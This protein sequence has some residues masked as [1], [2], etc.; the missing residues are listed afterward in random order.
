[1]YFMIANWCFVAKTTSES[2]RKLESGSDFSA[3]PPIVSSSLP[4]G[5]FCCG[6]NFTCAMS[7]GSNFGWRTTRTLL[8][9]KGTNMRAGKGF[10]TFG[11][12]ASCTARR[13]SESMAP[14]TSRN[15]WSAPKHTPATLP[16][17]HRMSRLLLLCACSGRHHFPESAS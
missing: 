6:N 12:N 1:M 9:K 3:S 5:D 15:C 10:A 2:S 11:R 8:P 4:E 7:T 16:A 13:P 17:T 14:G